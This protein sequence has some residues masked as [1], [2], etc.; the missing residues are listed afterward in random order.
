MRVEIIGKN[1]S[2]TDAMRNV[3]EKKIRRLEK[4]VVFDEDTKARILVRTYDKRQK[5]EVTIPAK[6]GIL[7]AEATDFDAYAAMD[8]VMD[9]LE[10][11]IRKQ[12]TKLEKRHR[13][14]ITE[15]L[16]QEISGTEE[17]DI[18]IRTKLINLEIMSVDEAIMKMELS[19]HS[20]FVFMDEE[21]E[22]VSVVYCR[23]DGGY[24]VLETY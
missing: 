12:K 16:I 10:G 3:F 4:Y 9:K 13:A 6:F 5:V 11:Q 8:L 7:R 2:I 17:P 14:S 24:G 19:D 1:V 18:P 20:F 22:H 23:K 15:N 21:T